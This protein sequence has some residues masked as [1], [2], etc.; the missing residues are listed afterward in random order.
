MLAA[1]LPP[2]PFRGTRAPY[3]WC[4]YRLLEQWAD[5]SAFFITGRDYVRPLTD[6]QGR[7][8]CESSVQMRLGYS[9]PTNLA[10]AQH[11]YAW[12]DEARF[13]AWLAAANHNPLQAFERFLTERDADFEQELRT[14]LTQ[15]ALPTA[16]LTPCNVPSLTAVCNEL[17]V[18]VI[19]FELGALRAPLYYETGYVD[20][21]GVNGN[22]ESGSR[23]QQWLADKSTDWQLPLSCDDLHRFFIT[24]L[25]EREP[26]ASVNEYELG[27]VLQVEDD[28]N[29]LAFGHGVTNLGLM[30]LAQQQSGSVLVRPHPG[31]RFA[32]RPGAVA[33]DDSCHSL[34][35]L[36]RC[37]KL[38]T[39]NSS[40]GVEALL[41]GKPVQVLG[42]N[43]C[44]FILATDNPA[45]QVNRLTFYM[46]GYLVPF[47]LQLCPDYLRFRLSKPS[48]QAIIERHLSEYMKQQEISAELFANFPVAEQVAAS[49]VFANQH[50]QHQEQITQ[51]QQQLTHAQEQLTHYQKVLAQ[52]QTEWTQHLQQ[53][54]DEHHLQQAQLTTQYQALLA[55]SELILAQHQQTITEQAQALSQADKKLKAIQGALLA[56]E[57]LRDNLLQSR[58]WRLTRP[59]RFV[60][61]L[62]KGDTQSLQVKWSQAA[63][64]E[65]LAGRTVRKVNA[66]GR[67]SLLLF[68]EPRLAIKGAQYVQQH[69]VKKTLGRMREIVAPRSHYF[70]EP[71]LSNSEQN[72][73]IL[74]TPHCHY[75]AELMQDALASVGMSS[76][77]I[78]ERPDTGFK[79]V[80]H[81]V[82]CPQMF[83]QLPGIY[84]AYQ[85]EQSVSSRWFTPEYIQTLENSYA[86][87][88]YSLRNIEFLQTQGLSYKQL[89]YLPVGYRAPE[90]VPERDEQVDVL[91]YGDV[92]NERRQAYI[93]A[94]QNEFSVKIVNNSFGEPL[95]AEMAKVKVI[96]NIHFYEGALL[97]T[98][99]LYECLSQQQIVVSEDAS[100]MEEHDALRELVDFVPVN[101]ITAMVERV[102][103]WV[104]NDIAREQRR[105]LQ[106]AQCEQNPNWFEFYFLRFLLASELITYEQFY[107]VSAKHIQ[108]N[109]DFICLGLPETPERRADFEQDNHYGIEYFPGL[110]HRL[111]WVGCGMSYKFLLQRA[112]DLNLPRISICEDDVEFYPYF[113]E[114]YQQMLTYLDSRNDWDV[115]AGLI[116]QLHD[117]LTILAC[118][119]QGQERYLSIDKMVSMVMNVYSSRFYPKLLAWDP[120]DHDADTNTIDRFIESHDEVLAITTPQ[121]LAGHKEVLN[122]TL[123]GFNNSTYAQMIADSEA[124][125]AKK[126]AQFD[127]KAAPSTKLNKSGMTT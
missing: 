75:L 39:I 4:Y 67:V 1:F 114:R 48:E 14:L 56:V 116:A 85:M 78:Y 74:T 120:T 21:S 49:V 122:S 109:S 45:E 60:T 10:P 11:N 47:S 105:A 89:Y 92:N 54:L 13:T 103:F 90:T 100:D 64:Q 19:H 25:R 65:G 37:Q 7:W 69:G 91:F 6:W 70:N 126:L 23:Y 43:A 46:F 101:D 123:W 93:N 76:T 44:N 86:V 84:V 111:G 94:L 110:R 121:F 5:E 82:I 59:L 88:D 36:Q 33:L 80:L 108:F 119:N 77:I 96:V 40:V 72:L 124:Q 20:F 50:K 57:Q 52:S 41:L 12:L 32:L 115:F 58:S 62:L 98:T 53:Q 97:E 125:L 34:A 17:G 63:H 31:S 8:E 38:L 27:V 118:D 30:S 35:F 117:D 9:L 71:A 16:I 42:D 55:E 81:F 102:R 3:L 106:L 113:A 83:A 68:R 24:R 51:Y 79:G 99:R 2:Y 112:H 29:L 28:S 22:T 87:F 18:A 107:A 61:R 104:N 127:D 95:Y 15:H 66:A 73:V 26:V